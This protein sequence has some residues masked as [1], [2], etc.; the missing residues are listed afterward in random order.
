MKK[1]QVAIAGAGLGG[2]CLAS[3]LR[4]QGIDVDVF[5]RDEAINSRTQGYRIRIDLTGQRALASC[6]PPDRYALFRD[7]CAIPVAGVRTLTSALKSLDDKQIYSWMDSE[8]EEAADLKAHRLTMREILMADILPNIH[9]NKSAESWEENSDGRTT[10]HFKDGTAHSCD[11]LVIADGVNSLLARQLFPDSAPIDTGSVCLYGTT[12]QGNE[13]IAAILQRGT[14]AIFDTGLAVIIDAMQFSDSQSVHAARH[15]VDFP[16]SDIGNYMYWALIGT[17][18][19]FGLD[20]AHTLR[21]SEEALRELVLTRTGA[22][23]PGLRALFEHAD[24]PGAMMIPVRTARPLVPRETGRVTGLGD[25]LHVMSPAAGLGANTA[26][27]DAALLSACL[28]KAAAGEYSVNAAITDYERKMITY[29]GAAI[30]ASL[31]GGQQ[32][33]GQHADVI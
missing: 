23:A 27:Q 14:T 11:V 15:Q 21:F 18:E 19:A 8:H 24:I 26:L 2:L 4:Q 5:E 3:G 28:G 30:R 7:T 17:R 22:W 12:L 10:L 20:A 1:I 29:S 32:L 16:L 33:F 31:E 25:A 13:A 6:F 9:F